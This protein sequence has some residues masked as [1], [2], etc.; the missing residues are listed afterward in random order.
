MGEKKIPIGLDSFEKLREEEFYYVD[1]T[2]MIRDLIH[3]WGGSQFAY[4]A[5]PF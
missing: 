3:T 2:A 1:Q 5:A 4:Q